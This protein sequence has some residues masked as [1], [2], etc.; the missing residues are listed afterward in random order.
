MQAAP[1]AIDQLP[2]GW[3][4]ASWDPQ[5]PTTAFGAM[6]KTILRKASGALTCAYNVLANN[7]E[8]VNYS[9][10]KGAQGEARDVYRARQQWWIESFRDAF[11]PVWMSQATL[12]GMLVLPSRDYR[13]YTAVKWGPRGWPWLEPLKEIQA[14]FLACD[15]PLRARP[16][17][18]RGL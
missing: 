5:H 15:L 11:Y 4:F 13:K 16:R 2:V 1:G 9:S 18:R 8:D 6:I 12:T 10:L 17:L 7:Y 3:E 14:A